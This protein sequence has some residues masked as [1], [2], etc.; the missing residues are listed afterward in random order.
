MPTDAT[1]PSMLADDVSPPR[2]ARVGARVQ[3]RVVRALVIRDMM[4]RYGRDNIGFLWVVLE[5]MILTIGV[6]ALWSAVKSP[7]EN[8]VHVISLVLSGY[9]PLTLWR[10][11][12]GAGVFILRRSNQILYHRRLTVW[13][14]VLARMVTEVLG[15]SLAFF[16]VYGALFLA[17]VV[18]AA[19]DP[20]LMLVGWFL[21]AGLGV[22][23]GLVFAGLT[24]YVEA[25]ERI[26][27][28]FQYMIIPLSGTFF[29]I[30]WLPK[31]A[32]DLI[33]YNPLVHCYEAFRAG[34]FGESLTTHFDVWYPAVWIVLLWAVGF[35][36]LDAAREHIH[37]G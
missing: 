34:F 32:Q 27:Q 3:W 18:E 1:A 8:G 20:A 9:M 15:V 2:G 22:G 26:V 7:F 25:T 6:T 31:R 19:A 36:L 4:V 10:H 21:L 5:P 37:G 23:M 17:G 11:T 12:S 14:V 30:D 28:P 29:L 33:W 13:D 24:E 16:V 35:K